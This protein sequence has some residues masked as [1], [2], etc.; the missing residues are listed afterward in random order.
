MGDSKVTKDDRIWRQLREKVK[1]IGRARVRVG[2]IDSGK[3]HSGGISM[4]ELAAIHEFGAPNAG[5]PARPFIGFTF[6]LRRDELRAFTEKL[7]R[8]LLNEKLEVRQA[9]GLLGAWGAAQ[10]K[11]TITQRL[12][13]PQLSESA[14]GQRTIARK[15]SSTTLVDTGQLLA[16]IS[17]AV[18]KLAK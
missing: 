4:A 15:G 9:L 1:G 10:I 17:W 3:S 2:V 18:D 11:R 13:R 5:I 14:A 7:A 6:Q 16:S 8:Q 12:V